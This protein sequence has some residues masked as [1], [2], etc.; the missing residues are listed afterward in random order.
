MPCLPELLYLTFFI[1]PHP[2]GR[3][4][5]PLVQWQC[6]G[7]PGD[8]HN[9]TVWT[10]GCSPR[11]VLF[12]VSP[13]ESDTAKTGRESCRPHCGFSSHKA[14]RSSLSSHHVESRQASGTAR[15]CL[16][17]LCLVAAEML[18]PVNCAACCRHRTGMS[19]S[20]Y[21]N[22]PQGPAEQPWARHL[23][24]EQSHW[25]PVSPS[26]ELKAQQL[27]GFHQLLPV[28]FHR[29]GMTCLHLRH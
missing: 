23:C 24:K 1:I 13:A 26:S 22:T 6:N 10:G 12:A 3:C 5:H 7:Y 16:F 15:G 28:P 27:A 25:H 4:L 9:G 8:P 18:A 14:R 20:G 11:C 19:L 17:T 29:C 2:H 21:L